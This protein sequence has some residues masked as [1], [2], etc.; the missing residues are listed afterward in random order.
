MP[1]TR[2]EKAKVAEFYSQAVSDILNEYLS[3]AEDE[4]EK[5]RSGAATP[6]AADDAV[7]MKYTYSI[8]SGAGNVKKK[9][10]ERRAVKIAARIM[11]AAGLCR[12]DSLEKCHRIYVDE[13]ICDK[14]I[15][16]WL[17]AKAKKELKEGAFK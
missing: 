15:E 17:L 3:A 9:T 13:K 8:S 10:V 2:Y 16:S 12:Y 1:M 6:K 5:C 7:R 14:C 4:K 11:Q